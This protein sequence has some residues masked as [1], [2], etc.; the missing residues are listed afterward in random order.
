MANELK[1]EEFEPNQHTRIYL[2]PIAGPWILGLF[3]YAVALFVIGAQYGHWFSAPAQGPEQSYFIGAFA[4][5]VGGL[6]QFTA[7]MW[8]YRARDGLSTAFNGIW[9][10][11]LMGFGVLNLLFET[12]VIPATA[13]TAA[14]P[15]VGMWFIMLAFISGACALAA[16]ASNFALFATMVV[17]TASSALMGIGALAGGN[18]ETMAVA[19][20]LFMVS[21]VIAWYTGGAAMIADTYGHAVLP[22]GEFRASR[23]AE[24]VSSGIGEPGV[25]HGQW[26]GYN[27]RRPGHEELEEPVREYTGA[28]SSL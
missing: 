28:D 12:G 8:A 14:L 25:L 21:A 1:T 17:A 2:Q 4:A 23:E 11:F 24:E 10:S 6:A 3:A 5:L 18:T 20:Y 13:A 7:A 15:S 9:G 27:K 22:V 16:V 19:G 26:R